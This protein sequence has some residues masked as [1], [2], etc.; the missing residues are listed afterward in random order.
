MEGY[1]PHLSE[2]PEVARFFEAYSR[3]TSSRGELTRADETHNADLE[4]FGEAY[5]VLPTNLQSAPVIA[6]TQ[7]E[8]ASGFPDRAF[9]PYRNARESISN[10][11]NTNLWEALE[12]P[13]VPRKEK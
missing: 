6:N 13:H 10:I 2:I 7:N 8:V 1:G 5:K 9:R 12:T 3:A 4:D 11:Q